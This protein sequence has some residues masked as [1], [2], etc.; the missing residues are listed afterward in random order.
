MHEEPWVAEASSEAA[1]GF[2]TNAAV[3]PK[4]RE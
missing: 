4:E 2:G 3:D 1:D